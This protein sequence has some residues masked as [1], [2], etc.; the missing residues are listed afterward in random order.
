VGRVVVAHHVPVD[1]DGARLAPSEVRVLEPPSLQPV[2]A[3]L[4]GRHGEVSVARQQARLQRVS[5]AA[6]LAELV[7]GTLGA[8][9]LLVGQ[10]RQAALVVLGQRLRV[11]CD[12][13]VD[14]AG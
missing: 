12:D 3:R 7:D 8:S 9:G 11:H 10:E 2:L 4:G 6:L 5:D 13:H 1:V 14:V